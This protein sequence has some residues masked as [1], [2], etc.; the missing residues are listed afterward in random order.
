MKTIKN[1]CDTCAFKG[2]PYIDEPCRS[3]IST[4][5]DGYA[6]EPTLWHSDGNLHIGDKVQNIHD[7]TT[8]EITYIR[9]PYEVF[10]VTVVDGK[11]LLPNGFC[12]IG[13]HKSNWRL[14]K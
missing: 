7:D 14:I 1:S 11:G 13:C 10:S 5:S 4:G 8:G 2:N 12:C 6:C 3:C 9:Y